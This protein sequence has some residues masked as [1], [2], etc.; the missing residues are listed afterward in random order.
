MLP[1]FLLTKAYQ[2]YHFN[3]ILISCPGPFKCLKK[4]TVASVWICLKAVWCDNK[5]LEEKPQFFC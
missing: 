1:D 5:Y 3:A 4:E 2:T